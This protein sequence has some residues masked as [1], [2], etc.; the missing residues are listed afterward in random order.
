M[1]A[2]ISPDSNTLGHVSTK[3]TQAALRKSLQCH[4]FL[5]VLS[6]LLAEV[7]QAETSNLD[8]PVG[9]ARLLAAAQALE[10]ARS[11]YMNS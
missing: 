4:G 8:N 9:M 2:T 10:A 5:P 11:S 1:N 3:W 6:A 7:R